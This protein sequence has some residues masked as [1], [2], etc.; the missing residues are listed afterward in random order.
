MRTL[1]FY[2]ELED[3]FEEQLN[4]VYE[5]VNICGYDYD[6][7]RA[8]RLIDEIAFDTGCSDFVAESYQE[9]RYSQLTAEEID[10]YCLSENQ[11]LYCHNDEYEDD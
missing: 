2:H 9:L 6:P 10:H 11:V 1:Y 3:M 4:E 5:P 8:L 7:G